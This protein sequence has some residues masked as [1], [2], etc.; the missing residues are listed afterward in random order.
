MSFK[1]AESK[2]KERDYSR[3]RLGNDSVNAFIS[4]PFSD[5]EVISNE[6]VVKFTKWLSEKTTTG[7]GAVADVKSIRSLS[8]SAPNGS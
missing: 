4:L 7:G 3:G 1:C 2:D 5:G 6:I 8:F